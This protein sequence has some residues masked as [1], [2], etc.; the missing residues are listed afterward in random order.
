[1]ETPMKLNG[2]RTPV[3]P[4]ITHTMGFFLIGIVLCLALT[5]RTWASNSS[6][7]SG[8]N[9]DIE[10]GY[11][12]QTVFVTT[13]DALGQPHNPV[14]NLGT[15]ILDHAGFNCQTRAYPAR[16][17]FENLKAGETQFALLVRVPELQD[18]C[19]YSR[20]PIYKTTLNVYYI[21]DKPPIRTKE[22]LK[23]MKVITIHGYSY[24][25]LLD[26]L[27]KPDNK[28]RNFP[29]RSHDSAFQMLEA[30]RGDY[31][32]DYESA[33]SDVLTRRPIK[34]IRSC[35]IRELDIYMVL[36]K[37]WPDAEGTMKSL[38]DIAARLDV[39]HIMEGCR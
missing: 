14:I 38:E 16:R 4:L 5:S 33:S 22:D 37:A 26:F 20:Q 35:P 9:P 24:G 23:G 36:S 34:H 17:L 12:D 29:T 2:H 31:L 30:N 13:R 39:T 7:N 32:L 19:I 15:A 21:G 27:D 8:Q 11:P 18:R 6:Y 25:G 10:F 1:M 28:I 3:S